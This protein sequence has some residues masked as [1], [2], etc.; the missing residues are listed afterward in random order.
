V[1][2]WIFN[3]FEEIAFRRGE[4]DKLG[5]F[6]YNIMCFIK[7]LFAGIFGTMRITPL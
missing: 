2:P 3:S 5:K 6:F 1:L 7:R 4:H